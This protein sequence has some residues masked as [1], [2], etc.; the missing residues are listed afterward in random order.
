MA[1][2]KKEKEVFNEFLEEAEEEAK[3]PERKAKNEGVAGILVGVIGLAVGLTFSTTI[4]LI[5]GALGAGLAV[6]AN[7]HKEHKL[8]IPGAILALLNLGLSLVGAIPF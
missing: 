6:Y 1:T 8:A 5:L 2:K 4:Q 3:Q 7:H